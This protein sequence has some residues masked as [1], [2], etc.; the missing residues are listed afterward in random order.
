M[1]TIK[2]MV[3]DDDKDILDVVGVILQMHNYEPVMRSNIANLLQHVKETNPAVVLLDV[4][5]GTTDGRHMCELI[6]E[7]EN[8]AQIKVILFSANGRYKEDVSKYKCDD[9]IEKP[10]DMTELITKLNGYTALKNYA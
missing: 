5:L 8:C 9:F 1:S 7:V 4:Q 3:V 2:I 6:K 10:F